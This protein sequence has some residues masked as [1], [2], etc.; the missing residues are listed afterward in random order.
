MGG[1]RNFYKNLQ[2]LSPYEPN[3]GRIHL[4]GQYL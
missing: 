4:A 2:R 1:G 3:L